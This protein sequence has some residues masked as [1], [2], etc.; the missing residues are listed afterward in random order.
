MTRHEHV[1]L[2]TEWGLRF[3]VW[4]ISTDIDLMGPLEPEELGLSPGLAA[5]LEA[6]QTWWTTLADFGLDQPEPQ[7]LRERLALRREWAAW[8][9]VGH[10]LARQVRAELP[11][12]TVD[13][14]PVRRRSV[15]G[16]LWGIGSWARH[17]ML[18]WL[19]R[20][21]TCHRGPGSHAEDATGGA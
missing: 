14:P 21:C 18:Q 6:W 17:T 11:G 3:P 5:R 15:R 10:E 7:D 20:R 12:V 16:T 2:M 9:R 4:G 1:E 13:H 19:G 8:R